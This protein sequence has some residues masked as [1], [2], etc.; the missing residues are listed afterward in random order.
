MI[1]VIILTIVLAK[2]KGYSFKP[3]FQHWS[4]Y[5]ALITTLFNLFIVIGIISNNYIPYKT[6]LF[7]HQNIVLGITYLS[8][9]PLVFKY[10]LY[11]SKKIKKE[12]F[13]TVFSPFMGAIL[14]LVIGGILNKITFIDW[15]NVRWNAYSTGDLII[16][17]YLVI[18]SYYSIVKSN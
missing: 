15:I 9:M 2:L 18:I 5:P 13:K 6:W 16:F 4:V 11:D 7:S 12:P 14:C 1:E 10:R 3:L 17:L 8:Y